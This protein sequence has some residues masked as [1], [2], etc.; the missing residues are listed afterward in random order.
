M[1]EAGAGKEQKDAEALCLNEELVDML[2][3]LD[4]ETQFCD[5]E[6]RP[7]SK[8]YFVYPAQNGSQQFKYFTQLVVWLL[9]KVGREANWGKYDDPNTTC[10]NMVI[11]LKDLGIKVDISPGKLKQGYGEGVCSVLHNLLA[12]VL[13]ATEFQ[14]LPPSFPE[15]ALAEEADVDS[16]QE[17]NSEGEDDLLGQGEEEDLMYTETL[18]NDDK[19]DAE[20]DDGEHG[21]LEA[22]VDPREWQLE[23]ERVAPK[24]KVS[25][26]DDPKEWRNHLEQ[27]KGYKG[28]IEG[29]F[30]N[31]KQQLQKLSADLGTVLERIRTKENFINT[32]FENRTGDHRE[33]QDELQRVT[34]QYNELNEVV[35][36]LQNDHK[37]ATEELEVVK[38]E[39][40]ERS[41]T[42]TDTQPCVK[43]KDAFKQL[44]LDVR[45]LEVRIGVVSHTLL[46]GKIWQKPSEK[47]VGLTLGGGGGPENGEEQD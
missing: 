22:N 45:Q 17:I 23:V 28:I 15:E 39:M 31:T 43:L 27:T 35:M 41:T 32:Q 1:A 12:G 5:K 33:Q 25:I 6:L 9:K 3:V 29:M 2:A 19:E 21:I 40:E 38:G 14:W 10:T 18:K 8:C 47:K 44:R 36:N 20:S 7:M 37:N 24:L 16:D 46:Q 42:V 30:P 11:A 4:Y 26:P 13:K 34:Q